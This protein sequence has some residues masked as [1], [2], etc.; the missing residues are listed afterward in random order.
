ML[1]YQDIFFLTAASAT[2]LIIL[3]KRLV[4]F[5]GRLKACLDCGCQLNTGAKVCLICGRTLKPHVSEDVVTSVR[6]SPAVGSRP[7]YSNSM[8]RAQ[9]PSMTLVKVPSVSV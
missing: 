1:S 8:G 7:D 6:S 9:Q 3:L 2:V 5:E 4:M